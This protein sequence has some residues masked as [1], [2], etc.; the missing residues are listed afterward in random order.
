MHNGNRCDARM[1]WLEYNIKLP[2]HFFGTGS[3]RILGKAAHK[4]SFIQAY[5]N[6]TNEQLFESY[7]ETVQD[8]ECRFECK[9]YLSH[10]PVNIL[11]GFTGKK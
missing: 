11:L 7:E 3:I 9:Q 2:K 4:K 6:T 8:A 5:S 1:Q 10:H